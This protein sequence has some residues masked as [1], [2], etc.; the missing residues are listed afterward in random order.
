MEIVARV[1]D[2]VEEHYV[3]PAAGTEIARV[4]RERLAAGEYAGLR[5][6]ALAARVTTDL[7]SVNGDGHTRLRYS[8]EQLPADHGDAT[9]DARR[10]RALAAEWA[11]GVARTALLDENIA[12]IELSPL[13]FGPAETGTAVGAAMTW[14][15]D[16]AGLVLDLRRCGGG[17]PRSVAV[18][19]S[20]LFDDEAVHVNDLR[21]RQGDV[22][23][24][25]TSPAVPG[26]RYGSG[27]P[28][29][30]LTSAG[31]FS[32]AEE[33]A[34][35]LQQLGRAT[36]VGERTP[37]GA[38]NRR[39]FRVDPHLE[40]TISISAAVNPVSGTNWDGTGVGPDL[41]VPAADALE[42]ARRHLVAGIQAG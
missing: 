19:C 2:L 4:L 33:L 34:Y 30:V 18:V 32:S 9:A 10:R 26:R 31:T 16:T 14:A 5:A 15:A 39:A 21:D 23:Q 12:L 35:D 25:W 24:Y 17:D 36:I 40:V 1:A 28:V 38:F 37:G 6:D 11:S 41:G 22:V 29:A 13:L 20:Y 27:R 7:Q 8:G 42:A 3:F